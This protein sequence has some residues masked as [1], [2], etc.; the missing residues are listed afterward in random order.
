MRNYLNKL[1]ITAIAC[2]NDG[3]MTVN[4]CCVTIWAK[5][6]SYIIHAYFSVISIDKIVF[7]LY[8]Y[9]ISDDNCKANSIYE[10]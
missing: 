10:S 7:M 8:E 2:K 4:I 5:V 1:Y 6:V 3:Y 9:V